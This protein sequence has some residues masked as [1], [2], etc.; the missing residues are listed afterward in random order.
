M[1]GYA[2]KLRWQQAAGQA[3]FGQ[4]VTDEPY[5][6]YINQAAGRHG[7][8]AR[9]IAAIIQAE[10]SFQPRAVS[11]TGAYGLMQIIPG[12]WQEVNQELQLC[13]ERHAGACSTACYFE[14]ELNIQIGSAYLAKLIKH[15]QGNLRLA[16]AAYNA[17][18]GAVD[19]AGGNIPPFSETRE[20]VERVLV[21]WETRLTGA[22]MPHI[23]P[24]LHSYAG[25]GL[26]AA[27]LF[28]LVTL[29]MLYRKHRSWRWR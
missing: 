29:L 25:W 3:A 28:W 21:N 17:G 9:L 23:W 6:A 26:T 19:R 1:A 20:Y 5:A 27:S 2:G 11:R 8:N 7:V 12:T 16:V 18:P 22:R 4:P 24:V 13:R 14:P 10:S 15:Y